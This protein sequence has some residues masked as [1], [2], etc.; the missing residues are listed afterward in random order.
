MGISNKYLWYTGAHLSCMA[1]FYGNHIDS[2]VRDCIISSALTLGVLQYCTKL[3]IISP[4]F[5][6]TREQEKLPAAN[7]DNNTIPSLTFLVLTAQSLFN[8]YRFIKM[9][10]WEITY[11]HNWIW[12]V[13]SLNRHWTQGNG[14]VIDSHY[15]NS[16]APWAVLTG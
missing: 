11:L 4:I 5:R 7:V 9:K 15:F 2:L 8:L 14:R 16:I 3:T 6:A 13:I 10:S 1:N 12:D